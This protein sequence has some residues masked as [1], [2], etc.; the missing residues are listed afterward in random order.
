MTYSTIKNSRCQI[1]GISDITCTVIDIII[2]SA[3]VPFI[4]NTKRITVALCRHY[5]YNFVAK[6]RIDFQAFLITSDGDLPYVT[7]SLLK[8]YSEYIMADK[9]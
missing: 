9:Q 1:F 8:S 4:N 2:D 5:E 6:F 7:P 3:Y